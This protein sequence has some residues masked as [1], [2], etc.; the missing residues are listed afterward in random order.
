MASDEKVRANMAEWHLPD[1]MFEEARVYTNKLA[2]QSM[3]SKNVLFEYVL[4]GV[5]GIFC[6]CSTPASNRAY[7]ADVV[8]GMPAAKAFTYAS[9]QLKPYIERPTV[10]SR[11]IG[12]PTPS[13][14]T[15]RSAAE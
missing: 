6:C 12:I 3:Y 10:I 4:S 8:D 7:Q 9:R 5:R 1:G 11:T 13:C 2:T 14:N 15:R